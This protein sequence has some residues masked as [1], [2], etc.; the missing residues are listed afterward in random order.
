MGE[1]G[2]KKYKFDSN[3]QNEFWLKEI[4]LEE[5][6]FNI[7]SYQLFMTTNDN[8]SEGDIGVGVDDSVVERSCSW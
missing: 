2:L 3:N 1:N 6:K 7:A 4:I 5:K 8:S